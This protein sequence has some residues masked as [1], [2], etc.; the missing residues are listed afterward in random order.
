[1]LKTLIFQ[2][3]K[4][5][6]KNM[7]IYELIVSIDSKFLLFCEISFENNVQFKMGFLNN[8]VLLVQNENYEM[9]KN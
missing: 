4:K 9:T 6:G 7:N 3:E 8:K 1:V 2:L 5:L